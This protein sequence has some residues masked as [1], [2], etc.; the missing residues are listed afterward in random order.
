DALFRGTA[1][2]L[3]GHYRENDI[4]IILAADVRRVELRAFDTISRKFVRENDEPIRSRTVFGRELCPYLFRDPSGYKC[5]GSALPAI[6]NFCG[7]GSAN[8]VNDHSAPVSV[9]ALA[10]DVRVLNSDLRTR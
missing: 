2:T 10:I 8:V 1:Q 4:C 6:S 3:N 5:H 7:D 9:G